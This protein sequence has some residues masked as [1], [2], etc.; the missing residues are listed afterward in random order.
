MSAVAPERAGGTRPRPRSL[1]GAEGTD[2][3]SPRPRAAYLVDGIR[4]VLGFQTESRVFGVRSG[5]FALQGP[6]QVVPGVKLE[7][8][9]RAVNL[10]GPARGRVASPAETMPG[11][12]VGTGGPGEI[13]RGPGPTWPPGTEPVP[14]AGR[15]CGRSRPGGTSS[16][17]SPAPRAAGD[18][19]RCPAQQPPP[20]GEESSSVSARTQSPLPKNKTHEV[21]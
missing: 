3:K 20:L 12:G 14:A 16:G 19:S 13:P 2:P 4:P 18:R 21:S 15:S 9:L 1:P 7:A 10:H 6:V 5:T 17:A 8:G 11:A